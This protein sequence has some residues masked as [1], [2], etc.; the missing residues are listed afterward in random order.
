MGSQAGGH[1]PGRAR[2]RPGDAATEH[3]EDRAWN[4]APT[5]GDAAVHSRGHEPRS[6][7]RAEWPAAGPGSDSPPRG[8]RPACTDAGGARSGIA[9]PADEPN[10]DPAPPAAV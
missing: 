10:A 8:A 4:G 9:R 6:E 5:N 2:A 7:D 1:D 3:C